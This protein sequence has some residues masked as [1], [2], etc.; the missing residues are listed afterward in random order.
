MHCPCRNRLHRALWCLSLRAAGCGG[1]G[2]G[3]LLSRLARSILQDSA[4]TQSL[5][6]GGWGWWARTGK[7]GRERGGSITNPSWPPPTGSSKTL[8]E[9]IWGSRDIYRKRARESSAFT[10]WCRSTGTHWD[11]P[12]FPFCWLQVLAD[13]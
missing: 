1:D 7:E 10:S 8:A 4:Q 13:H 9:R 11:N 6:N 2:W 3:E 5:R 12:T